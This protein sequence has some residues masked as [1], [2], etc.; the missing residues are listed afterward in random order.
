[1]RFKKDE[2]INQMNILKPILKKLKAEGNTKELKKANRK[3][4]KL[5]KEYQFLLLNKEENYIKL[6]GENNQIEITIH[7]LDKHTVCHALEMAFNRIRLELEYFPKE[8]MKDKDVK[9]HD[10]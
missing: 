2:V 8:S 5:L 1:M 4:N 7:K 9:T 3:M 6:L 10:F